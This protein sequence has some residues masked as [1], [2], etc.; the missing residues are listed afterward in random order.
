[1]LPSLTT[2]KFYVHNCFWDSNILN[3]ETSGHV[4]SRMCNNYAAHS[5]RNSREPNQENT[6]KKERLC[7]K[8]LPNKITMRQHMA[9]SSE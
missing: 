5:E 9:P 2:N 1:M 3:L 4:F 7:A 8:V 6:L